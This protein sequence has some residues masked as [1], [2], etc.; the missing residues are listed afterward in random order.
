MSVEL[1]PYQ[2]TFLE[3]MPLRGI[4]NAELGTGKTLMS[5]AHYKEHAWGLPLLII[6]P[7]SKTRS[8]DWERE[9][10]AYFGDIQP[11]YRIVS[12]ERFTTGR[13]GGK[14]LWW[15]FA[16]KFGGKQHAVIVDE[17]HIGGRNPS[18]SFHKK[19]LYATRDATFF[20]GLSGTPIP[21]GWRDFIGYAVLYHL[22]RTQSEFKKRY[23]EIVRYKGFP[24]IVDIRH[25][26]ELIEQWQYISRSLS[27]SQANEL[28]ARQFVGV[29]I[30]CP[31]VYYEM[32]RT[33]KD[34][35][36]LLDNPSKLLHHLRQCLTDV[37]LD[38]LQNI[39]FDTEENVLIFYNYDSERDKL[40]ELLKDSDK[41][42][43]EIN[44]HAHTAPERDAWD[45]V[46]NSV[47]LCHYKSASAGLE[48]TYATIT[49]YLSPTYSWAEY[50]QSIGRTYRQGQTKKCL[51]YNFRTLH[52]VEVDIYK[53]LRSKQDFKPDAYDIIKKV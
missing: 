29:D 2:K 52:T 19:L 46:K 16:P 4:M 8:G 28:P 18:S 23:F 1:Y 34:G 39:L 41:V 47:T 50:T 51:Y 9:I 17:V 25:E 6:A 40:Q 27:R 43:Y 30:E 26:D 24:E 48:L 10:V 7:A 11:E 14:P 13:E 32:L 42:I 22:T 12:R 45:A 20:L 15:E 3:T 33:R 35:D 44:G 37:K 49:V 53:A 5:L 31:A 38:K 36:E 21:N